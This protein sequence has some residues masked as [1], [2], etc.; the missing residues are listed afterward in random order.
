MPFN[1]TGAERQAAHRAGRSSALN[2]RDAGAAL[3]VAYSAGEATLLKSRLAPAAAALT[4]ANTQYWVYV[5]RAARN[6]TFNKVVVPVNAAAVGTV[7]QAVAIATTP[8]GPTRAGQSLTVQAVST[9][10]TIVGASADS[11][12]VNS[13]SLG[14]TPVATDFLWVGF[15]GNYGTTQ[16]TLYGLTRDIGNGEVLV[17][18]AGGL[19]VVGTSYNG[20]VVAPF[21]AFSAPDLTLST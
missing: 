18:A 14:Y 21:L 13:D 16:P 2:K 8:F 15:F 17:V 6:Q 4:T 1:P 12:V 19:P 7:S 11:A 20:T 9:A 10:I 3:N 5:G